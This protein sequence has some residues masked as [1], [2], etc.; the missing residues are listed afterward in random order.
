[1]LSKITAIMKHK[2][3]NKVKNDKNKYIIHLS[4]IIKNLEK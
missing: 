2:Y 3:I 1:M 4:L